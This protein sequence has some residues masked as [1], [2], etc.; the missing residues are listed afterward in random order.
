VEEQAPF[1]WQ[2]KEKTDL[3]ETTADS[4]KKHISK[5]IHGA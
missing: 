2:L 4:D 1:P 3:Y 5:F